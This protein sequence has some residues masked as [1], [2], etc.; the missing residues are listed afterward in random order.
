MGPIANAAHAVGLM[1]GVIIGLPAYIQYQSS[2]A[3]KNF[4]KGS[5]ADLNITG[6]RRFQV[7]FI[8]PYAPFWFLAIA[9]VVMFAD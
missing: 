5:W 1:S 4:D 7:Q 8:D 3:R 6:W 2:H 9:S